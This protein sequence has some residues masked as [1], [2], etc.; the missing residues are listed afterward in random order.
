MAFIIYNAFFRVNFFTSWV[1][2]LPFSYLKLMRC[3]ETLAAGFASEA[4]GDSFFKLGMSR[5][6]LD[7]VPRVSMQRYSAEFSRRSSEVCVVRGALH[8]TRQ[9]YDKAD[10]AGSIV[11][12]ED[13]RAR[14][15]CL[16]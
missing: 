8:F 3:I 13:R 14:E 4:T 9:G 1:S 15:V 10:K 12:R 5:S 2:P 11:S 7:G 16:L 6:S